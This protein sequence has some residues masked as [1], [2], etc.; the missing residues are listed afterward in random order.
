MTVSLASCVF[1]TNKFKHT[2]KVSM[3]MCLGVAVYER[4]RWFLLNRLGK[5]KGREVA[6]AFYL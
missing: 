3:L 6:E 5:Q 2:F 4:S 1:Q